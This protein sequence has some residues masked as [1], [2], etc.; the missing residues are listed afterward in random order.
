MKDYLN[1]LKFCKL[2]DNISEDNILKALTCLKGNV[3]KY[4]KNDVIY[5]AGDE[6]NNIGVVLNG[7]V[8]VIKDDIMG[9]RNILATMSD[10]ELF[11]ETFVFSNIKY[12]TVTIEAKENCEILF[13]QF[14]QLTRPCQYNCIFHNNLI[15][16]MLSIISDKNILLY[17]KIEILSA[18]TTRLKLITYLNIEMNKNNSNTFTIP[19]SRDDL[20]NYLNL[21]RSSMSRE[22]SKMRAEG[23]IKFNKNKFKILL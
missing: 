10:S 3:K 2:F 20:A 22:L 14:K 21:D 13:I 7:S 9:N 17:T 16:N 4:N 15:Q 5:L 11:G 18:K 6:I 8:S 19:F 1:K 23:I 12:I